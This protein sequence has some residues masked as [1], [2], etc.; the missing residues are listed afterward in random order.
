M[1]GRQIATLALVGFMVY[2]GVYIFIYLWRSFRIDEPD[3]VNA[4]GLW[5]GDPFARAI[6]VSVL[7]LMGLVVVLHVSALIVLVPIPNCGWLDAAYVF[8]TESP[9][10]AVWP[11]YVSSWAMCVLFAQMTPD[12]RTVSFL[13]AYT[14]PSAVVSD[15]L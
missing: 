10:P 8:V 1:K 11:R 2:T 5:H 12:Q 13:V 3:G 14:S 6:L 9:S 7:F 4:V 15:Q